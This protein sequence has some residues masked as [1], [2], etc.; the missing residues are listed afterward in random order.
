[1]NEA[2]GAKKTMTEK[3]K[4]RITVLS[5]TFGAVLLIAI[6]LFPFV[7]YHVHYDDM[8][9]APTVT[10]DE[11]GNFHF[12]YALTDKQSE[13]FSGKIVGATLFSPVIYDYENGIK[14]RYDA[15]YYK[16]SR[17][18]VWLDKD[19]VSND[20]VNVYTKYGD[21]ANLD[22][23]YDPEEA[24]A[25]GAEYY[26]ANPN[27]MRSAYIRLYWENPDGTFT[28]VWEHPEAEAIAERCGVSYSDLPDAEDAISPINMS[29]RERNWIRF[30]SRI[31]GMFGIE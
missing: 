16:C 13:L 7:P 17:I 19:G 3:A 12:T 20:W 14:Y 9:G 21:D 27:L 4:K 11:E 26:K 2:T 29:E 10:V 18:Y 25:K 6:Y 31:M 23:P 30:K 28:L 15:V 1:M 22:F 8:H 24:R 5:I